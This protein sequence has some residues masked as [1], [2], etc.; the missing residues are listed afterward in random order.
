M[1]EFAQFLPPSSGIS[2]EEGG[3]D[4][5]RP[6]VKKKEPPGITD[7][8][9][10]A[11]VG[12]WDTAK[13]AAAP[14]PLTPT[15]PTGFDISPPPG[16]S[17]DQQLFDMDRI[18]VAQ[19][20]GKPVDNLLQEMTARGWKLNAPGKAAP[21]PI[22]SA[23]S[24]FLTKIPYSGIEGAPTG[25]ESSINPLDLAKAGGRSAV[26][27]ALFPAR[28]GAELAAASAGR[29]YSIE[30]ATGAATTPTGITD[31]V[32]HEKISKSVNDAIESGKGFVFGAPTEGAAAFEEGLGI[33]FEALGYVPKKIGD[34][35]TEKTGDPLLGK[36]AEYAALIGTFKMAHRGGKTIQEGI[37]RLVRSKKPITVETPPVEA[38]TPPPPL[39]EAPITPEATPTPPPAPEA[40]V[41][42][43]M[44]PGPLNSTRP[45]LPSS[46]AMCGT[47]AIWVVDPCSRTRAAPE[48]S[49]KRPR[50]RSRRPLREL[51]RDMRRLQK[52]QTFRRLHHPFRRNSLHVARKSVP[53]DPAIP[54]ARC[55]TF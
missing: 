6:P 42:P 13:K 17:P 8:L 15:P 51:E 53:C 14:T 29:A 55:R 19:K 20:N 49:R 48:V 11:A 21:V 5:F 18:A 31:P 45:R 39:L 16:M 12:L 23:P 34:Y 40:T 24:S 52:P 35:V 27:L 26:E 46:R 25:E 50:K 33:P 44:A 37:D 47:W 41:A 1:S 9:G 28:A 22:P 7:R 2:P 3:F 38:A 4:A 32:L 36:A 10:T 43:G 30:G 54:K